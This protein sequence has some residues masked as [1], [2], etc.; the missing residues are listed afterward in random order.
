MKNRKEKKKGIERKQTSWTTKLGECGKLL[1]AARNSYLTYII[2][3]V[4]TKCQY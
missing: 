3:N 4:D 2:Y 1:H